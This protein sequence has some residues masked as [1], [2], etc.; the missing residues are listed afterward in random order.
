[1][2]PREW[3]KIRISKKNRVLGGTG[4][5]AWVIEAVHGCNLRCGHCSCR[6][7]PRG[8]YEFMSDET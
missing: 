8:Q 7:L 6:L 3:P 5:R 1:M 2:E 4:P